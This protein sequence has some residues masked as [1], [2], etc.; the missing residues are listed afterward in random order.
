MTE[1]LDLL[2]AGRN[3]IADRNAW[4][5]GASVQNVEG[6][7]QRCAL[8]AIRDHGPGFGEVSRAAGRVLNEV[9]DYYYGVPIVHL[10]DATEGHLH[11]LRHVADL[12][13]GGDPWAHVIFVYD[14]AIAGTLNVMETVISENPA[15]LVLCGV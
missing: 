10:N 12:L 7:I 11:V 15:D 14:Q 1:V 13:G 3:K 4:C 5:Q 8:G 9:S 2:V 6:Q